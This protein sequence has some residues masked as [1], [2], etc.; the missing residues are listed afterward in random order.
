MIDLIKA[1]IKGGI[2]RLT[3]YGQDVG[4]VMTNGEYSEKMLSDFEAGAEDE[5]F[6]GDKMDLVE[7]LR[8]YLMGDQLY[9][10]LI[11]DEAAGEIERLR[12]VLKK[13]GGHS[14]DCSLSKESPVCDCGWDSEAS[15]LIGR[16]RNQYE[17]ETCKDDPVVC[18]SIP[19][20]RHCER[21]TR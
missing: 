1:A 7:R 20:L 11:C 19:G 9:H 4:P 15:C 13:Y 21:A 5:L 10:P 12:A 18:A 3:I 17:C 6:R 2:A 16:P 14:F 8:S